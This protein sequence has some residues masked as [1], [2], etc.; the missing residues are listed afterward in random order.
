VES[1]PTQSLRT[2]P[3]QRSPVQR[4]PVQRSPVQRLSPV[5][6]PRVPEFE[7]HARGLGSNGSSQRLMDSRPPV[8]RHLTADGHPFPVRPRSS[9]IHPRR[10]IRQVRMDDSE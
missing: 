6:Q 5:L 10:V 8:R 3:V 9:A 4:S 7:S 1:T 2:S